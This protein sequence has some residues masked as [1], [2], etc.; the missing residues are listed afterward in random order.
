ML[1]LIYE[2]VLYTANVGDSKAILVY[3]GMSNLS[4]ITVRSKAL[5]VSHKPSDPHELQRIKEKGGVVERMNS[6][7]G[8]TIGP[9]RI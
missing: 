1:V 9:M 6:G 3:Q 4:N 2:G 7:L 5:T 8:T